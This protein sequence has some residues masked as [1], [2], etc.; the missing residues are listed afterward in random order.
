MKIKYQIGDATSPIGSGCKIIAH[1]CNTSG[2]WGAGFVLAVSAKWPVAKEA[3]KEWFSTESE[4]FQLGAI[5][6]VPVAT[7]L[8]VANMIAQEGTGPSWFRGREV[9]PIRYKALD[10]CLHKLGDHACSMSASVHLPRIGCNLA[11]GKWECVEPILQRR[12]TQVGIKV[13]VYDLPKVRQR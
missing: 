1:C 10:E 5:Q 12:L 8:I 6:L 13:F 3:Y 2:A 4:G 7:D 9:P 11:G